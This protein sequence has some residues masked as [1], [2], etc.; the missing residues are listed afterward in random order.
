MHSVVFFKMAASGGDKPSMWANLPS[1]F[2][3]VPPH[4]LVNSE[5]GNMAMDEDDVMS[6]AESALSWAQA[7][8]A[9]G[10]RVST[11]STELGLDLAIKSLMC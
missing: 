9:S 5:Y 10:A 2:R 1:E 6:E 4:Q 8:D 7:S 11:S 3:H